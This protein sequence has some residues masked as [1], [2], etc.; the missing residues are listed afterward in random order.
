MLSPNLLKSKIPMSGWEGGG[1]WWTQLSTFDAESIFAKKKVFGQK[2]AWEWFW[3]LSKRT[4]INLLS[5]S[6]YYLFIFFKGIQ[7]KMPYLPIS[8][9]FE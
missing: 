4:T 1:G 9:F 3:T 5:F 2:S 6:N 7:M 8:A